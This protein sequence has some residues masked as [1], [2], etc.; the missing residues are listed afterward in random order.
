MYDDNIFLMYFRVCI[1]PSPSYNFTRRVF[2][3]LRGSDIIS[4]K[5]SNRSFCMQDSGEGTREDVQQVENRK[6]VTVSARK[7]EANRQN[8]LKSTGPKTLMGKLISRRNA[9]KHGLFAG[10]FMD[11]AAQGED[12][13]AYEEILNGLRNDYRPVGMAEKLEVERIALC[14][15]KL[16]RVW[17]H[18]NAVNRVA[19]RTLGSKELAEKAEFCKT[20]DEKEKAVVVLLQSAQKEIEA[21]GEISQELKQKIFATMPDFEVRFSSI[22]DDVKE[23]LNLPHFSRIARNANPNELATWVAQGT[24]TV[25]IKFIE[26][27]A[28]M[29]CASIKEVA[30]AQ[31]VIPNSE[32]LD[33]ILRYETTIE[34]SLT[35]ALDRLDRHRGVGRIR[36]GAQRSH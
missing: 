32:A 16:R 34:R 7:I 14:W 21:T 18:E 12:N 20:Q 4:G 30:V 24:V 35:R 31:H 2:R 9:L 19:L 5:L 22:E 36:P 29:R 27:F 25:C 15:W 1:P 17:R 10:H 11:F 13:L 8:A 28:Q 6:T 26:E 33:K 23:L 3:K